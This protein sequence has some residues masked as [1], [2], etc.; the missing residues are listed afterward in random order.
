MFRRDVATASQYSALRTWMNWFIRRCWRAF[1]CKQTHVADNKPTRPLQ[2]VWN[3]QSGEMPENCLWVITDPTGINGLT[4]HIRPVLEYCS[5]VWHTGFVQDMKLLEKVQ[6]RWTKQ[7]DGMASLSYSDRLKT[8]NLY[9]IQGRLLRADQIMCWKIFHGHS[10]VLPAD[11]FQQSCQNRTRGHCFKIFPPAI[12]T[13]IRKRFFS[14]RCIKVWNLLSTTTVCAN[15]ISSFKHWLD[16]DIG[17]ALYAF[18]AW[19]Q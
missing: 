15:T 3:L 17:E 12:N 4:T 16:L 8:L 13:D 18:T 10:S 2:N 11:L 1:T 19:L 6:R 14:I 5:C 9:S 7:I